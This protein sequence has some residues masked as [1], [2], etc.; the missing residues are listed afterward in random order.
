MSSEPPVPLFAPLALR[1]V[2]L[3]NRIVVSPMQMY[4]TREGCIGDWHLAHLGRF[5]LGGAGLVMVEATAI[6]P[7]ARS[8]WHDNGLWNDGHVAAFARLTSL[9][10]EAGAAA[11]IQLQHAGRKASSQAPWHGFGPLGDADRERGEAPWIADGPTTR[12][13]SDAYPPTRAMTDDDIA[14]LLDDYRAAARRALA[15]GFDVVELHA[16]HGYLLHSFLSPLANTRTDRWGGD[17]E[18]RMRLPLAVAAAVRD[19]WPAD[20]PLF[21]RMSCVDGVDVGWSLDDS[22]VLAQ[23][24]RAAGVDV[25][26]CSSGGMS[27]PSKSHLVPRRPGFQV[28]FARRVRQ[29]AGVATM[30]VGLIREPEQANAIVRDGDADLVALAREM[31]WDPNWPLHAA[32]AL[33]VG[34]AWSRWPL[35][36]GWWLARR[37]RHRA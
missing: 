12:G 11:G 25:V 16:A 31:L 34:D 19:A 28:P 7:L 32:H 36:F 3:R 10:H 15:A 20:R 9:L 24:L 17:L 27:L 2:A 18:R 13:W 4:S 37:G 14:R 1:G 30:A 5:A 8:T 35:Q 21:F 6:S 29:E 23:R 33:G 26:D 22:V